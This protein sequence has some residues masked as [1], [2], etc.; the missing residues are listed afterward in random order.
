MMERW[1]VQQEG[2][3]GRQATAFKETHTGFRPQ[4]LTLTYTGFRQ[5]GLSQ[6]TIK[7][8]HT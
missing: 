8:M 6:K 2:K 1:L 4:A 5:A 3:K 7:G